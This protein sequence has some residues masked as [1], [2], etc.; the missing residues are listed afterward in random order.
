LAV[1]CDAKTIDLTDSKFTYFAVGA[2]PI[3]GQ[4]PEDVRFP[5]YPYNA[6]TGSFLASTII[7]ERN[8]QA[9]TVV[10]PNSSFPTIT[11]SLYFSSVITDSGLKIKEPACWKQMMGINSLIFLLIHSYNLISF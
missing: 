4:T 10:I 9:S 5:M 3:N 6:E 7:D 2:M 1:S 8:K 11:Y